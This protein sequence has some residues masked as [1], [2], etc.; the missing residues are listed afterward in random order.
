MADN[1]TFPGGTNVYVPT[2]HADL[3]VAYI[4]NPNKFPINKYITVRKVDKQIGYYVKWSNTGQARITNLDTVA[5]ADGNDA[6]MNTQ[7]GDTF[8][9]PQFNAKR[10]A[11]VD[12]AGYLAVEQGGWDIL[13]KKAAEQAM[14]GMTYRSYR[15]AQTLTTSTNY[16][17][18]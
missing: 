8:D 9:F 12:R 6:P 10:H 18:S 5:W 11:Y 7:E 3:M 13:A 4:R 14:K 2:L 16:V 17:S 15:V 1:F